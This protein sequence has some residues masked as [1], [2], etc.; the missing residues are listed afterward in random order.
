M[1]CHYQIQRSP[2]LAFRQE[3]PERP[4][5]HGHPQREA[6]RK[7]WVA[8]ERGSRTQTVAALAMF[9][10]WMLVLPWLLVVL[11]CRQRG[12]RDPSVN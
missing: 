6:V 10:L 8:D 5:D 3:R 2:S 9:A 7:P 12:E 1:C 11:M 4:D